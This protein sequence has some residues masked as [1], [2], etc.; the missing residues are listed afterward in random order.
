MAE[1]M[2]PATQVYFC[3][4]QN[5]VKSGLLP[6]EQAGMGNIGQHQQ[7]L[8]RGLL[9]NVLLQRS[10]P[11]KDYGK[12]F[13]WSQKK[14]LDRDFLQPA[15]RMVCYL[16]FTSKS[17]IARSQLYRVCCALIGRSCG[18]VTSTHARYPVSASWWRLVLRLDGWL[19]PRSPS[20]A[21]ETIL[22]QV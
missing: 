12:T 2:A 8:P 6:I 22:P 18:L 14:M 11:T 3:S 21:C 19:Y 1:R 20:A 15:T 10:F 7:H 5:V 17:N 4:A 13:H 9:G 16:N